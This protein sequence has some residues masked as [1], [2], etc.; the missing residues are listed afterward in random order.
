MPR[1]QLGTDE[2]L[3]AAVDVVLAHGF[4]KTS[5]S[6]IA[7]AAGVSK[8]LLYLRFTDKDELLRALLDREFALTVRAVTAAVERDER[9][10]LLS[11]VYLHTIRSWQQRPLLVSLYGAR[12]ATLTRF[13]QRADPERYRRR[14]RAGRRYIDR[15]VEAG[16][17]RTD[18]DGR[19]T[20]VLTTFAFGLAA[21]PVGSQVG[22]LVEGMAGMVSLAVD[23]EVVDTAPGK[24]AFRQL[25]ADLLSGVGGNDS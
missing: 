11:R 10:G 14:V 8:G 13:V 7:R 25:A 15:M 16:M 18:L 24:E 9:G 23:A 20:D 19:L 1:S 2:L 17:L 5:M 3:E 6:D 21:N 12:D 4:G 22:E